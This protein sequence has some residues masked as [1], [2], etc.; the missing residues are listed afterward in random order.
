MNDFPSLLNAGTIIRL[1]TPDGLIIDSVTY[2]DDWYIDSAKKNGGWSLEK[3]DLN[4][5]CGDRNNWIA[6]VD[7]SGGTP[8][9]I[10]SV[11]APNPENLPPELLEV[12]LLSASSIELIFSES[13][14]LPDKNDFIVDN[15]L[16]IDSLIFNE[17]K[18]SITIIFESQLDW[19]MEYQLS[20]SELSDECGNVTSTIYASFSRQVIGVGDLVINEVLYNPFASGADFVELYNQSGRGIDISKMRL[21]T[22]SDSLTLKSI[23]PLSRNKVEFPDQSYMVFTND[24]E[25]VI[26]NYW[27][28][29]PGSIVQ[30][31]SFP[32]YPDD[33]GHVVLL[34]DSLIVI[35]EFAYSET[36]QSKWLSDKIGVSLERRLFSGETNDPRNWHSAS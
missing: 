23:Y 6:T 5:F 3:I 35:D 30:M 24:S 25:N 21:A 18:M 16:V 4:R 13:F 29:N 33:E 8:G 27:V 1:S 12:N 31:E 36:M 32:S 2:S 26:S 15:V 17:E 9:K 28:P 11:N 14:I 19:N 7:V 20:I 10:N 34:N 22:R